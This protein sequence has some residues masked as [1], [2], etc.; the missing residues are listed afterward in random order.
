MPE[1]I[2]PKMG[3]AM[4]EGKL[5]RWIKQP[6]EAVKKG[7][8]IAEIETDKVNVDIE[9]EWD[10][11][12]AR[13]SANA[14]D[15]VPVGAAIAVI[16]RPGEAVDQSPPKA[17]PA[18]AAAAATA[19]AKPALAQ[20]SQLSQAAGATAARSAPQAEPAGPVRASPLARRLAEQHRIPLESIHGTGPQGRVTEKDVEDAVAA[21]RASAAPAAGPAP[22]GSTDVPLTRMRQTIGRR[23]TE[24]KQTT[25]HI[26]VTTSVRLDAALELR[27]ELNDR[28]SAERKISV[29]DLVIKAAAIALV[30]FP[31]LNASFAGASIRHP[32]EI[33]IN[34]AVSLPDGLISPVLHQ[35]DRKPLSQIAQ[36][37]RALAERAR[38][39][40]LKP[41]DLTGGTFT[42]SNLGMFD[43]DA[44]GAII[45]PPQAAVLAVATAKPQPVVKDGR[46]EV[47]TVMQLTLSSD[48]RVTDGAESAQFLGE[49]KRT[50]ENPAWLIGESA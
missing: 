45:T 1:V 37:A 3:D 29:N 20:T 49:V 43:V 10:G 32:G 25:P 28:L 38:A 48:H 23:M 15:V 19:A 13:V 16:A 33:N 50:L 41:E 27:R 46:L 31:N 6:G 39:G 18:E 42:V 17:P 34:V 9:A 35:C 44:F 40:H 8:P 22:A 21:G 24:S 7:E 4:T 2:M 5:L 47:A 26:Y 14:G 30:K 11:V 36:E 12:L